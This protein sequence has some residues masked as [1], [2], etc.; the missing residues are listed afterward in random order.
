MGTRD[1]RAWFD[2]LVKLQSPVLREFHWFSLLSG[3]R[4][5]DVATTDVSVRER[6]VTLRAPKGGKK[7][8]FSLCGRRPGPAAY[9][10]ADE[11]PISRGVT[12]AYFTT[13]ALFDQLREA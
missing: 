11:P 4:R 5:N 2:Q 12:D 13:P 3:L 8:S 7:R 10:V 1:I 6:A 9:Q